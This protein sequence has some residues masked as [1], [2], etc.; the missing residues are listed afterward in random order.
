MSVSLRV[1][2]KKIRLPFVSADASMTRLV[3]SCAPQI[4]RVWPV[5]VKLSATVMLNVLGVPVGPRSSARTSTSSREV[6]VSV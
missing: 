5:G 2:P 6:I 1:P 3:S 4:I